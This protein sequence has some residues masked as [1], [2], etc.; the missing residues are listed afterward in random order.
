MNEGLGDGWGIL[1]GALASPLNLYWLVDEWQPER[2]TYSKLVRRAVGELRST[3]P[4]DRLNTP[5]ATLDVSSNGM[6]EL[7]RPRYS[8]CIG[9]SYA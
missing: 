6:T 7:W 5:L 9:C 4:L 8:F 3:E 1:W 2:A